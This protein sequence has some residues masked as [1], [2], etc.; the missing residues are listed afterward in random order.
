MDDDSDNLDETVQGPASKTPSK[1]GTNAFAL[2]MAASSSGCKKPS[3]TSTRLNNS[4][5]KRPRPPQPEEEDDETQQQ[6]SR[7]VLCP[8]G[9]GK[10]I[11]PHLINQHLDKCIESTDATATAD[12]GNHSSKRQP[13]DT[14]TVLHKPVCSSVDDNLND[15]FDESTDNV[16]AEASPKPF[17][18]NVFDRMMQQSAQGFG[19]NRNGKAL[20]QRMH[21]HDDMRVSVTCYS[22]D[23]NETQLEDDY[24]GRIAW[25]ATVQVRPGT[26]DGSPCTL[27]QLLVSSSIAPNNDSNNDSPLV[28]DIDQ[29][30]RWVERHSRLSVPVLKSILQKSVRRR[31]PLPSVRVAM[32]L[33]DKSLSDL[34]RRLVVIAVEDSTIHPDIPLMVWLMIATSK[35][36]DLSCQPQTLSSSSA[37]TLDLW[38]RIF[39]FVFEMA[40]CRWQDPLQRIDKSTGPEHDCAVS[41]SSIA[42]FH[43]KANNPGG[44]INDKA[45]QAHKHNRLSATDVLIWSIFMRSHYGGMKGDIAMLLEA[46]QLWKDRFDLGDG[47]VHDSVVDRLLRATST[48]DKSTCELTKWCQIPAYVH[49]A[50]S[51][52]SDERIDELLLNCYKGQ[53]R[54]NRQLQGL[55]CLRFCDVTTGGVDFHCSNILEATVLNDTTFVMDCCAKLSDMSLPPTVPPVPATVATRRS[56]LEALLKTCMWKYSAGVNFRQPLFMIEDEATKNEDQILANATLKEFWE[57][58][59][60]PRTKAFSENYVK[61][62]L[63]RY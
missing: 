21:L 1:T 14:V 25:S 19:V 6:S 55:P 54:P 2:L 39:K 38:K 42:S 48:D 29:R 40:S 34:L 59:I 61:N 12:S 28:K 7:F 44:D 17:K 22:S 46:A 24:L 60:R 47:K 18:N 50:S 53:Q 13:T 9:C 62:R 37:T 63:A 3:T 56:W 11:L 8:G 10:H 16:K 35:D 15:E 49:S 20:V 57:S 36:F 43:K 52:A 32:E 45:E 33:A 51:K 41:V 30:P 58:H 5:K 23:P 26:T 31:K 4:G 27:V